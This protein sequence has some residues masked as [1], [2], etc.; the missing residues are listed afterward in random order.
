MERSAMIDTHN[1]TDYL[2]APLIERK[3]LSDCCSARTA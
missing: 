1:G 2:R 3:F